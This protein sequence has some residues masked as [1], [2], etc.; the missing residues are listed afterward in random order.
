METLGDPSDISKHLTQAV[1][2]ER[3]CAKSHKR[4]TFDPS[5]NC[6]QDF[7]LKN[8]GDKILLHLIDK[9]VDI[10][11]E[12]F[13]LGMTEGG[14]INAEICLKYEKPEKFM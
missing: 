1:H 9:D 2:Q 10:H 3:V 14:I 11:P 6:K 4:L 7:E 8:F 5:S 12:H 13:C